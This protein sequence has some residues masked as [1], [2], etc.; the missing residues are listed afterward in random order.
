MKKRNNHGKKKRGDEARHSF[1]EG[2]EARNANQEAQNWGTGA[3][4]NGAVSNVAR[5]QWS[6]DWRRK[7]RQV[8]GVRVSVE[9]QRSTFREPR[10]VTVSTRSHGIARRTRSR[11]SLSCT[12][13]PPAWMPSHRCS[14]DFESC[15]P[16][17]STGCRV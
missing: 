3:A 15:A 9:A 13:M 1:C 6:S 2:D 10:A 14:R 16:R 5:A 17:A 8:S 11:A 7:Q 4:R 12:R